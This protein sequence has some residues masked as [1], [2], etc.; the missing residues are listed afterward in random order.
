MTN[1]ISYMGTKSA[2]A[3]T[4]SQ[5]VAQFPEGP[6][7]DLFAGMSA[8]SRAIAPTRNV[9]VNDVQRFSELVN[10]F[11]FLPYGP[12]PDFGKIAEEALGVA[13]MHQRQ[14]DNLL[15]ED[16]TQEDVALRSTDWRVLNSIETRLRDCAN[17]VLSPHQAASS[18]SPDDFRLFT[19]MYPGTYFSLRQ[20][21][22]I[23]SLRKGIDHSAPQR[24]RKRRSARRQM[25]SGLGATML[26]CSNSTGHF[27][28]YLTLSEKNAARVKTKRKRDI[29]LEWKQRI[30]DLHPLEAED[31]RGKNKVFRKD[32]SDLLIWLNKKKLQPAV[33]YADPPYTADHYSR[34]YHL[35][36]T[37]LLYDFPVVSGKGRYRSDRFSSDWSMKTKVRSC[38]EEL[39]KDASAL[40]AALVISYPTNGLLAQSEES[41]PRLMKERF[42]RV[43][44]LTPLL[45][46]HS[47]MGASKGKQRHWVAEQVFIGFGSRG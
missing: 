31:W 3:A 41:I 17:H 11:H 1:I 37:M 7:L 6:F 43:E 8:V 29:T 36:E 14:L 28:Q 44:R 22:A 38:F 42:Y 33:I 19:N 46:E 5:V 34:F 15:V 24:D 4:I 20:C 9:W 25:L 32:A 27:A 23:D 39:V 40:G 47:T 18:N 2:L 13:Q 12:C 45:H 35:W 26:R 10:E 21:I 30:E 16:L